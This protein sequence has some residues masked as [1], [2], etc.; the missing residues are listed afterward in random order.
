M[1]ARALITGV[2]GFVGSHLADLLAAEPGLELHGTVRGE[3]AHVAPLG[4]RLTRHVGDVLDVA[5][6]DSI[7]RDVRPDFVFH[8]AAQASVGESWRH[9][10]ESLTTN[11]I[12]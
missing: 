1:P 8:L 3:A 2:G 12:S 11:I 4:E 7:I 6:V 5:F 10:Q 9:P